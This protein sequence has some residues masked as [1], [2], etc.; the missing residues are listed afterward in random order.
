MQETWVQFWTL[1]VRYL[2]WLASPGVWPC[3]LCTVFSSIPVC[4][5]FFH[6]PD[7]Q[8]PVL[9]FGCL[10]LL[11]VLMCCV[12]L[13]KKRPLFHKTLEVL[14]VILKQR[15]CK[16]ESDANPMQDSQYTSANGTLTAAGRL[17][18]LASLRLSIKSN[19]FRATVV[20]VVLAC[21]SAFVPTATRATV[22]SR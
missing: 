11:C 6:P 16:I 8:N 19:M 1:L 13:L 18:R 12:C 22:R 17:H 20:L 15:L 10:Y 4:Y 3:K 14:G 21:A 5:T 2:P 9:C 7:G